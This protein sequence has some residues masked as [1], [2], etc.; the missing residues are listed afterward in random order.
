[1]MTTTTMMTVTTS[2]RSSQKCYVEY[3]PI[4]RLVTSSPKKEYA[5]LVSAT[6]SACHSVEHEKAFAIEL[7]GST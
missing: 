5:G 6:E 1:M 4:S 2:R 3:G 7:H